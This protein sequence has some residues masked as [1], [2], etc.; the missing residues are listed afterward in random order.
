M[1]SSSARG[2]SFTGDELGQAFFG[3]ASKALYKFRLDCEA[4]G[5]PDYTIL[6]KNIILDAVLGVSFHMVYTQKTAKGT[7]DAPRTEAIDTT[8]LPCI[9]LTISPLSGAVI[10]QGKAYRTYDS[11]TERSVITNTFIPARESL[12]KYPLLFGN[13]PLGIAVKTEALFIPPRFWHFSSSLV[14]R[15]IGFNGA[16]VPNQYRHLR[17]TQYTGTM[18]KL[19]QWLM[20]MPTA[21]VQQMDERDQCVQTANYA[22]PFDY[23]F[24]RTDILTLSDKGNWWLIAIRSSGIFCKRMKSLI[25]PS[26]LTPDLNEPLG[27]TAGR[28][29]SEPYKSVIEAFGTLPAGDFIPIA[30][31]DLQREI[32]QN[33]TV[34][35]KPPAFL[36]DFFTKTLISPSLCW[37]TNTKG[38]NAFVVVQQDKPDSNGKLALYNTCYRLDL[39]FTEIELTNPE[40]ETEYTTLVEAEAILSVHKEGFIQGNSTFPFTAIIQPKVPAGFGLDNTELTQVGAVASIGPNAINEYCD[41]PILASY[42]NDELILA[43]FFYDPNVRTKVI[44]A[45]PGAQ[46]ECEFIGA[47]ALT[48]EQ[49]ARSG[50]LIYTT[51]NDT[52]GQESVARSSETWTRRKVGI[53]NA[54]I[55]SDFDCIEHATVTRS[56]FFFWERE[57]STRF[58]SA[59]KYTHVVAPVYY[60]DAL[61]QYEEVRVVE[62]ANSTSGIIKSVLDANKYSAVK[63]LAGG[64]VGGI[65]SHLVAPADFRQCGF[66]APNAHGYLVIV[67]AHQELPAPC[68]GINDA[69]DWLSVCQDVERL[70]LASIQVP[71]SYQTSTGG[72]TTKTLKAT[73]YANFQN[74]HVYEFDANDVEFEISILRAPTSGQAAP[75]FPPRMELTGNVLGVKH[76]HRNTFLLKVGNIAV[77][78]LWYDS[79]NVGTE[80]FIGVIR[81]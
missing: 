18:S 66:T 30:S 65:G 47:W 5:L 77:P 46:G 81:N 28:L 74:Q 79:S 16:E 53:T 64:C 71:S 69:G 44:G 15:T 42:V 51:K 8:P 27:F 31:A 43:N 37:T 7:I 34:K 22:I 72:S 57:A 36:S 17:P 50:R 73:T 32:A 70:N 76:I 58:N 9:D 52:R 11:E 14:S 67:G 21:Y 25:D 78:E 20:S 63:R 24:A 26:N 4:R 29:D 41:T 56:H 6:Q 45:A 48:T 33:I 13:A 60:R 61:I 80:A 55:S 62:G 2:I 49:Q 40:T 68:R 1:I 10:G 54:L 19:V 38:R 59:G 39:P 35:L 12:T 23:T 75:L 3:L